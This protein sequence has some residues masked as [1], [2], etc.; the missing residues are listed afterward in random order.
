MVS[1]FTD[2]TKFIVWYFVDGW[3]VSVHYSSQC[4]KIKEGLERKEQL[5]ICF[6]RIH[7]HMYCQKVSILWHFY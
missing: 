1:L 3:L 6:I 5:S 4:C 2:C 7:T